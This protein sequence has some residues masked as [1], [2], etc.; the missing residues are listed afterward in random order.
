MNLAELTE[1]I[2]TIPIE[3][4]NKL[5][6]YRAKRKEM[7]EDINRELVAMGY[8]ELNLKEMLAFVA[9]YQ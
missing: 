5:G 8:D 6:Y 1:F 7:I 4:P 9:R 2:K 3:D